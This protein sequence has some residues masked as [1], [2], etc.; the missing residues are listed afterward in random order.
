MDVRIEPAVVAKVDEVAHLELL[1][2]E[3]PVQLIGD[4][5][6]HIA[7]QQGVGICLEAIVDR[8]LEVGG[9]DAVALGDQLLFDVAGEAGADGEDQLRAID[10]EAGPEPRLGQ[11]D[12][13]ISLGLGRPRPAG[14]LVP[15]ALERV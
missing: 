9:G 1:V 11:G 3:A 14:I 8:H 13:P 12:Q 2:A 10:V 4:G 6:D 5:R 7:V 15:H